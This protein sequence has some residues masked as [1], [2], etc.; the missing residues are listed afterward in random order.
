MEQNARWLLN[1]L[2]LFSRPALLFCR[3]CRGVLSTVCYSTKEPPPESQ[4][5][6]IQDLQS[7]IKI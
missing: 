2:Y 3:L 6:R 4:D 7:D 5:F 1:D